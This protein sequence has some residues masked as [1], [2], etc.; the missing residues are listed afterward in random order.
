MGNASV[1]LLAMLGAST[2]GDILRPLHC[3]DWAHL[4]KRSLQ[5]CP[6]DSVSA[7]TPALRSRRTS[8]WPPVSLLGLGVR[9][10]SAGLA[11]KASP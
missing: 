9:A 11:G 1:S 10:C 4:G 6:W 3:L 8:L 7:R 2:L 5:G